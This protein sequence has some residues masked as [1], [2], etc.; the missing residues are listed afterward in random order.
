L[1]QQRQA[2]GATGEQADLMEQ[3]DAEGNEAC[4][5]QQGEHIL[6]QWMRRA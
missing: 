3:E 4:C 2:G 5:G 6:I 1:Q